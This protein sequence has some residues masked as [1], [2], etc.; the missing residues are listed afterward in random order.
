[1]CRSSTCRSTKCWVIDV[2]RTGPSD[3]RRVRAGASST[4]ARAAASS[5]SRRSP[6]RARDGASRPRTRRRRARCPRTHCGHG[7]TQSDQPLS[8]PTRTARLHR[9]RSHARHRGAA[10]MRSSPRRGCRTRWR[11]GHRRTVTC[12]PTRRVDYGET[13]PS[14]WLS[15]RLVTAHHPLLW[16][17]SPEP[18]DDRRPRH[19]RLRRVDF[20]V[21]AKCCSTSS[22]TTRPFGSLASGSPEAEC[23]P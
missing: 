12:A 9:H 4:K 16:E 21:G 1:M 7:R 13:T 10:A 6:R 19:P 20:P 11:G 14:W 5:T 18:W 2:N 3:E 22:S 17:D 15:R 23:V 8:G